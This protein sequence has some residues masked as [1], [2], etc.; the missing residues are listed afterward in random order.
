MWL[1]TLCWFLT[2]CVHYNRY[3]TTEDESTKSRHIETVNTSGQTFWVAIEVGNLV[4]SPKD[5]HEVENNGSYY[6]PGLPAK[7]KI[8]VVVRHFDESGP[9]SK[10]GD[11]IITRQT[12]QSDQRVLVVDAKMLYGFVLQPGFIINRMSYAAYFSIDNEEEPIGILRV[13]EDVAVK[14]PDG[15]VSVKGTYVEGPYKGESFRDKLIIDDDPHD[16]LFHGQVTGWVF[17]IDPDNPNNHVSSNRWQKALAASTAGA[18]FL[19]NNKN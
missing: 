2:G 10:K 16:S 5:F 19:K 9:Q 1:A 14:C 8:T 7:E 11:L 18:I 13:G 6:K 15:V 12:L 4:C 3:F 17:N